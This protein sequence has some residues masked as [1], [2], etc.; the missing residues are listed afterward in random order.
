[1]KEVRF[2]TDYQS[3]TNIKLC[4]ATNFV[5]RMKYSDYYIKILSLKE[6][7]YLYASEQSAM[8]VWGKLDLFVH[9]RNKYQDYLKLGQNSIQEFERSE[10]KGILGIFNDADFHYYFDDS[11][12]AERYLFEFYNLNNQFGSPFREY[13]RRKFK[14]DHFTRIITDMFNTLT[15]YDN[16]NHNSY[17]PEP[18][19]MKVQ[20]IEYLFLK[21]GKSYSN[22]KNFSIRVPDLL[23]I[24]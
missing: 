13:V 23:L 21:I 22:Y 12:F 5:D 18:Y 7:T 6:E 19:E 14:I 24:D 11:P 3:A 1:M 10:G 8:E 9:S 17:Y 2:L 4:Q 16:N 20:L 15:F